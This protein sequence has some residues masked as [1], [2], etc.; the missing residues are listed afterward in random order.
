MEIGIVDACGHISF[1]S[2]VQ[3]ELPPKQLYTSVSVG[4]FTVIT[5]NA[6]PLVPA[7]APYSIQ[8][9][10]IPPSENC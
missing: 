8:E 1:Q 10:V 7:S 3:D 6:A 4:P 9:G 5:S 2:P